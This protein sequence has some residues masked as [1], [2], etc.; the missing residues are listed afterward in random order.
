MEKNAG[1]FV[2]DLEGK[3]NA[4]YHDIGLAKLTSGIKV[5]DHLY[6]GSLH[7]PYMIRLNVTQHPARAIM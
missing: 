4:H 3:P 5:G 6:F 1:V 7:Y 2:V